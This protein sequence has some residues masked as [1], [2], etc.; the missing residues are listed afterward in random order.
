MAQVCKTQLIANFRNCQPLVFQ[1]PGGFLHPCRL[2]IFK[3]ALSERLLKQFPDFGLAHAGI[4]GLRRNNEFMYSPN[5]L[6]KLLEM[7]DRQ[8]G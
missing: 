6:K 2:I 3:N 4:S 5:G 8:S 1:Q 7:F